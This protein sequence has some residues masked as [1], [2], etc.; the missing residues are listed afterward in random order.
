MAGFAP[1]LHLPFSAWP[2]ADKLLWQQAAADDSDPF[3]TAGGA[4]LSPE[5]KRRY[6]MG[7]RRFLGFL[8]IN[9]PDALEI[10]PLDRLTADRVR[11]FARHLAET[12]SPASVA[13]GV[14]AV[15]GAARL[16]VPEADLDWLK[17]MK[18]RLHAAAPPRGEK[19]PVIT[20]LQLLNLGLELMDEVRPRLGKNLRLAEAIQ[21]RDGLMFA[22]TGFIPFRRKNIAAIDILQHMQLSETVPSIVIPGAE[23]KTG[24]VLEY[25]IPALL[26]PYLQD[27]RRFARARINPR[28]N[29][30][31]LWVS[32]KGGALS[33]AAI[34]GVFARHSA[35]RLGFHI[36]P[37]DVRAAAGTTWAIYSPENIG[38]AQEL[39]GHQDI[40]TT[41]AHYNRATGIQ[42]SRFYSKI[43]GKIRL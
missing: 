4:H 30:T 41:N 10:S 14:E 22:V 9:E 38:V 16:M 7:W 5:S 27:Y 31:A 11:N 42:A 3:S 33:Y 40:R 13:T 18:T 6:F 39:L 8:A 43:L 32:P 20:S 2:E 28:G 25:E 23:T 24:T 36:R 19:G 21:Y 29:S 37:H 12:C 1:K 35:R 15:H 34:W 26:M 17:A